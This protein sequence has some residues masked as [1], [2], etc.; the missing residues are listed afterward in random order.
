M[1]HTVCRKG[2]EVPVSS[3]SFFIGRPPSSPLPFPPTICTYSGTYA[4]HTERRSEAIS[5][6]FFPLSFMQ[7]GGGGGRPEER[8]TSVSR[9]FL[10]LSSSSSHRP[11]LFLDGQKEWFQRRAETHAAYVQK[12]RGRGLL[13]RG[14]KGLLSANVFISPRPSL[15]LTPPQRGKNSPWFVMY[16]TNKGL[17]HP[18]CGL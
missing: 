18:F 14:H 11:F 10:C 15:P 4:L 6:D 13:P 3:A 2:E 7:R 16:S 1:L 17:L 8:H 9:W 12:R 5:A